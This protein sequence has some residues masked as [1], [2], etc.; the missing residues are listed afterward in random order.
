MSHDLGAVTIFRF[1]E[2]KSRLGLGRIRVR[3]WFKVR[4]RI[5]VRVSIRI[6]VRIGI[7]VRIFVRIIVQK[8]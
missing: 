4:I 8:V 3:S 1:S 2:I 6:R 7:K 5:K